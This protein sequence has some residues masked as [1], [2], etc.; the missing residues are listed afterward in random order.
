MDVAVLEANLLWV[1]VEGFGGD[2]VEAG[3]EAVAGV[4]GGCAVEVGARGGGGGG[5]GGVRVLRRGG[6]G[7]RARGWVRCGCAGG[8]WGG[9]R[10]RGGSRC[11]ARRGRSG[12]LGC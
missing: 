9:G 5:G 7:A 2:L 1:A 12:G 10:G 6:G 8:C 3:A 4:Y 11:P